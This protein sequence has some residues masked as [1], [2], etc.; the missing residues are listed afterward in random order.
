MGSPREIPRPGW[1]GRAER[2]A[3]PFT[4][5]LPDLRPGRNRSGAG[6]PSSATQRRAQ[7]PAS[8]PAR[9]SAPASVRPRACPP[10]ACQ[11]SW[12]GRSGPGGLPQA[13][14]PTPR[15][16][17]RGWVSTEGYEVEHCPSLVLF[18]KCPA[19]SSCQS[20]PVAR[21]QFTRFLNLPLPLSFHQ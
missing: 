4:L 19:I 8:L 18:L 13:R 17:S 5:K 10:P 11:P 21:H 7:R 1:Q 3:R 16:Q 20:P 12:L 6:R 9:S 15:P 2:S 14:P